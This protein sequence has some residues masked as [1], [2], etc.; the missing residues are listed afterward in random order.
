[1]TW[2]DLVAFL[3]GA[4]IEGVL[5]EGCWD[6]SVETA[7][8]FERSPPAYLDTDRGLLRIADM[9]HNSGALRCDVVDA[10][11]FAD[12]AD[13]DEEERS[14][15]GVISLG[16]DLLG[17]DISSTACRGL[18]CAYGTAE[19]LEGRIIA[20]TVLADHGEAVTFNPWYYLGLRVTAGDSLES[21]LAT[22]HFLFDVP[23]TIRTWTR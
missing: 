12:H 17:I 6:D 11:T 7:H 5:F 16:F 20:M 3:D 19:A 15:L 13:C 4:Q 18:R 21:I 10:P 22:N 1:M 14:R 23:S 2:E 9:A 8:F